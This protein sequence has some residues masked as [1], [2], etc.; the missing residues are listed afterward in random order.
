[1]SNFESEVQYVFISTGEKT[2]FYT[3]NVVVLEEQVVGSVRYK[4]KP[5]YLK[6]LST[7][8]DVANA[9]AQAY[10]DFIGVPFIGHANFDLEEIKRSSQAE[11]EAKEAAERRTREEKIAAEELVYVEARTDR[12][13]IKGKYTGKTAEEVAELDIGYLVYLFSTYNENE[14]NSLQKISAAIAYDYLTERVYTGGNYIGTVGET[15]ELELTYGGRRWFET[16]Y[17]YNSGNYV[18]TLFD[19]NFNK[20]TLFSSAKAFLVDTGTLLH[21]TGTVKSHDNLYGKAT[22]IAKPK[23]VKGK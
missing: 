21:V 3:L 8:K 6:N 17:G 7:N 18:H 16:S 4:E 22:V 9:K 23:L 5:Y 14:P 19:K 13:F 2:G 1:M 12:I 10:A 11:R 15:V 20:V